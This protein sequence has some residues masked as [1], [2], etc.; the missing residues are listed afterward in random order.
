ML[1]SGETGKRSRGLIKEGRKGSMRKSGKRK[2]RKKRFSLWQGIIRIRTFLFVN[3]AHPAVMSEGRERRDTGTGKC[4][5]KKRKECGNAGIHGD[6][7]GG[8]LADSHRPGQTC[9]D[10]SSSQVQCRASCARC[11]HGTAQQCSGHASARSTHCQLPP[12]LLPL[13]FWD[14]LGIRIPKTD[15]EIHEKGVKSQGKE[16]KSW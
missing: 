7:A 16:T 2:N 6:R 10:P 12:A 11:Q 9:P 15:S 13:P 1:W 8:C 3:N 4:S 5:H 14:S